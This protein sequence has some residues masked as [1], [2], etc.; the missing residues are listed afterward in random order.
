MDFKEYVHSS[1]T[2]NE[3][4]EKKQVPR[5]I[6]HPT[7]V[8]VKILNPDYVKPDNTPKYKD[9]PTKAGVK[10]RVD[11]AVETKIQL[12]MPLFIR[13]LEWAKEEAKDDVAIHQLA[14]RLAAVNGVADMD[15]Y[16]SLLEMTDKNVIKAGAHQIAGLTGDKLL[17]TM[18]RIARDIERA[19]TKPAKRK[20]F[21]ILK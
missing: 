3:E 8:G 17:A 15:N 5:Y 1:K 16:E 13:I 2:L 10:I 12:T 14:E 21:P 9:H 19:R 7:K 6:D 20:G 18:K 4:S 11:E